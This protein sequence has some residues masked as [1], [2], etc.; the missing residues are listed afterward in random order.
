MSNVK[1]YTDAQILERVKSLSSFKFF[2]ESFWLCAIRSN[3]DA[4]NEYDDKF[5]L[6][7]GQEFKGVWKGT[8]NAGRQGLKAFQTY[9]RAG[10][11]ILK[12]D[13]IVYDSHALGTHRG[14]V[15]GYVQRL[16]M[17]YHRDN[18]RDNLCEELGAIRLDIIGANIHPN[19]YTHG[20]RLEKKFIEGWSLACLVFAIRSDFDEFMRITNRQQKLTVCIL[21]EF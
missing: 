13:V 4:F 19:N 21:K 14:K 17:P 6:F 11:A 3:E 9:N 8:T 12:G 15:L 10:C 18:D 16:S 20:S 5:Y 2:P 1:N 7:K